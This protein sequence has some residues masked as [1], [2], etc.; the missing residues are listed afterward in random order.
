MLAML[1]V[2]LLVPIV[3]LTQVLDALVLLRVVM[4]VALVLLRV[5]LLVSVVVRMPMNL[6][7]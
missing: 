6:N 4:L 3:V 2:A 1:N 5:M 7:W